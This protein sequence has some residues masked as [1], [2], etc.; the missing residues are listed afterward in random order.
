MGNASLAV[1]PG[2]DTQKT[3]LQQEGGI[4]DSQLIRHVN[5]LI[6]KLPGCVRLT[7]QTFAGIARDLFAWA[8]L[9]GNTYLAIGTNQLLQL[10]SAG[11]LTTISPTTST[12]N[13][14]A[15][16]STV[17]GA[18]TG[19]GND[20]GYTPTVGQWIQIVNATYIGGLYLQGLYRVLTVAAPNY[21]IDAGA[22]AT[23][24]V[25]LG[26]AVI[27]Y[28]TTNTLPA[29][30]ITIGA[31]VFFNHQ[32]FTA[33]VSTVVGGLTFLGDFD[34]VVT[35]GPVFT[36][37]GPGNATSTTTGSENG[38]NTRIRYLLALPAEQ[39]V[40]GAYGAG[41]YGSGL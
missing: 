29:V 23:S 39:T 12:S 18:A 21:T 41:P 31:Y 28:S 33:G 27:L 26:G 2:V 35:A 15:P 13:L 30:T 37:T 25:V 10:F 19:T 16:F 20:G 1:R 7:S 22:R 8:D 40:P 4:S 9:S 3:P 5:G 11:N 14:A 24:T 32:T 17:N 38:G 6:Q 36:I 34:V